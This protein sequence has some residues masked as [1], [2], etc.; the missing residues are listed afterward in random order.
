MLDIS[1]NTSSALSTD[2]DNPV[3]AF[4]VGVS[5][6]SFDKFLFYAGYLQS[7]FTCT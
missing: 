3:V 4:S 1:F 5:A 6:N 7:S 2:F